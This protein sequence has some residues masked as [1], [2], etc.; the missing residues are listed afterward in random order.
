MVDTFGVLEYP[1]V[2]PPATDDDSVTDPALDKLAAF[3]AA[4]LNV[5]LSQAWTAVN[6]G[7]KFVEQFFTNSP[8]DSTFNERDLPSLFLWRNQALDDQLTDDWLET[9]T[10]VTVLWV[11]QNADQA[12]RSLRD[13]GLNGFQ[14][15]I[16][17]ALNVGRDPAWFDPSDPDPDSLNLGSVIMLRAG[18]FRDP[19][20]TSCRREPLAIVKDDTRAT[21]PGITLTIKISEITVWDP[22]AGR[23][24]SATQTTQTAGGNFVLEFQLPKPTP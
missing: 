6:P 9:M 18:L 10:D 24:A 8:A 13:P 16:S 22:A 1:T 2:Q 23:V 19:Y 12:K 15:T 14:K 7:K 4:V 20:V 3:L 21:Y 17:R 5:Q 11:P